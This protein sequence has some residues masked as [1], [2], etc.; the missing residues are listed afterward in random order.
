MRRTEWPWQTILT[1]SISQPLMAAAA[2][3]TLAFITNLFQYPLTKGWDRN[4]SHIATYLVLVLMLVG[5]TLFSKS[6]RPSPFRATAGPGKLLSQGPIMTLFR[7]RRRCRSSPSRVWGRA[8][9]E[10]G[11]YAYLRSIGSHLE[12]TFQYFRTMAAPKCR[13]A[14]ENFSPPLPLSTGLPK[15]PSFQIGSE[16][17]S[18]KINV[19]RLAELD[20]DMT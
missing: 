6:Q 15:T 8:P 19:R 12:H 3:D 4:W 20:F 11:F 1:Q 17:N 2:T 5:A 13:G 10:N 18:A 7:M 14:R 9:A 16:W